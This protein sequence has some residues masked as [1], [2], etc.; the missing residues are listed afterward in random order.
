[1]TLFAI[2]NIDHLPR[3]RKVTGVMGR[4]GFLACYG[5]FRP[6]H[7]P[8]WTRPVVKSARLTQD[9]GAAQGVPVGR[10][11]ERER[12][13][14]YTLVGETDPEGARICEGTRRRGGDGGVRYCALGTE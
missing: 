13:M 11:D 1:M 8:G 9:G 12:M 2:L 10:S 5:R 4:C 3:S 14:G 6:G 7:P